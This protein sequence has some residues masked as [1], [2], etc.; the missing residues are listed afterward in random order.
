MVEAFVFLLLLQQDL[1]HSIG[2][3]LLSSPEFVPEFYDALNFP[4]S[5]SGDLNFNA[6]VIHILLQSELVVH[7]KELALLQFHLLLCISVLV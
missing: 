6:L 2:L 1:L 3:Y 4:N 5:I 7:I